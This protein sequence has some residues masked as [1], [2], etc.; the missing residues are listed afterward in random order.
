MQIVIKSSFFKCATE[1]SK[2]RRWA[3]SFVFVHGGRK[4]L[5]PGR[6]H[7][8]DHPSAICFLYSVYIRRV[9]LVPSARLFEAG[10]R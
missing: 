8:A 1:Q 3:G 6:S 9:V 2:F 10:L 5:A 4:I 7:K